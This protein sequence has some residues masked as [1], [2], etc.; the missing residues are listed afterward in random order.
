MY[1]LFAEMS[2]FSLQTQIFIA[3]AKKIIQDCLTALRTA[4]NL[5]QISQGIPA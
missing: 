1:H 5:K 3:Q 4:S 2:I